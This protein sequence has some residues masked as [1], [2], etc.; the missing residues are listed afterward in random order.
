MDD[1]KEG[2]GEGVI[3]MM[4]SG[5]RPS[6]RMRSD[7]V[8]GLWEGDGLADGCHEKENVSVPGSGWERFPP[9]IG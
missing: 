2:D 4:A 8:Q 3:K 5:R 1:E 6:W 7:G 9:Y